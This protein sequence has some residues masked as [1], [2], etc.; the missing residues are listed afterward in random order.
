MNIIII[1]INI[2]YM[3]I[4]IENFF[5]CNLLIFFFCNNTIQYLGYITYSHLTYKKRYSTY[6]HYL[7]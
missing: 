6:K 2:A 1:I 5:F 3:S 4:I 7:Q